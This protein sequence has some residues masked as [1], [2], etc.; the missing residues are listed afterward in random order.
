MKL[1]GSLTSPYAR[2]VR[3]VLFEKRIECLFHTE[4]T[5]EKLDEILPQYSPLAKIPVLIMDDGNTLYDSRVIVD[6]L[7][8]VSPVSR[9]IPEPTRQRIQVKRWE[10]LADGICDA[11]VLI[12]WEKKRPKAQQNPDWIKRQTAKV[13]QGIKAMADD[14]GDK[15]FCMGD[16]YSLADIAVGC[17]LGFLDLRFPEIDWRKT[18]PNLAQ[19]SEKLLQRPSF[20]DTIPQG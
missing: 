2:K 5:P 4:A 14:L 9:L 18:Y 12:V 11:A 15:N 17:A 1:I 8:S 3:I 10:A 13:E 16:A 7:D 19:F 20:K 6:Y